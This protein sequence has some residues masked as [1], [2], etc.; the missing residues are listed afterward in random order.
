MA[1]IRI[2]P[3]NTRFVKMYLS[4]RYCPF[5]FVALC[6][7]KFIFC[8]AQSMADIPGKIDPIVVDATFFPKGTI[9]ASLCTIPKHVVWNAG[10]GKGVHGSSFKARI[11]WK[12][13]MG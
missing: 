9:G 1:P 4:Y 2:F 10:V 5:L 7:T 8:S 6:A 3:N 13:V 12:D 11:P